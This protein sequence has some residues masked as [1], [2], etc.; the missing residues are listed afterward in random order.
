MGFKTLT[1]AAALAVGTTFA[2]STA[3]A[4][5]IQHAGSF[6]PGNVHLYQLFDSLGAN[7]YDTPAEVDAG[8]MH[9]DQYWA[10]GG[11]GGSNATMIFEISANQS[12]TAFG[13]FDKANA[14]NK[15]QL[16]DG[17]AT[18]GFGNGAASVT[19]TIL[20]NGNVAVENSIVG[21]F[22]GNAF[23]YYIRLPNGSFFYS[24][25]ALNPGGTD[26]MVTFRGTGLVQD[27]IQ[28]ADFAPGI[29][30]VDEYIL[31]WEDILASLPVGP[32]GTDNDYNDLVILVESVNTIPE[33][34]T[35]AVLGLG[36]LG[37]GMLRRRSTKA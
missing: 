30:G 19:L 8:Q 21:N 6:D 14:A 1:A 2:A 36:L 15:V 32:G 9:G 10:I 20:A 28:I 35:L 22:A 23:G 11:S 4:G 27:T 17:A 3:F 26:Q 7:S 16:W 25:E 37:L 13:V 34:G 5:V 24:D 29:W 12:Q 33:P 18:P 31:A